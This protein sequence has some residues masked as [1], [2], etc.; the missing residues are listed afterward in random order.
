MG[1]PTET[2]LRYR[3]PW[4]WMFVL[5]AI[6]SVAAGFVVQNAR[7]RDAAARLQFE[8]AQ[9]LRLQRGKDRV[10]EYFAD[11]SQLANSGARMAQELP[12]D[13]KLIGSLL[14]AGFL[15][16]HDTAI[17]GY[18]VFYAPYAFDGRTRLVDLY[19][20]AGKKMYN[21]YDRVVGNMVEVVYAG[22]E[23]GP[24]DYTRYPWFKEALARPREVIY[25]GPYT[26]NQRSFI[27]TSRA[28]Y[29][30]GR[31]A[32]VVAVDALTDDFRKMLA[33]PLVSGDYAWMDAGSVYLL[34]TAP[35]PKNIPRVVQSAGI[36]YATLADLHLASDARPLAAI[37][38]RDAVEAAVVIILILGMAIVVAFG[39]LQRWRGEEGRR[40]L[41]L[42]RTKLEQE[43][44]TRRRVESELRRVAYLDDLTGLPNRLA[45]MDA[46]FALLGES[47]RSTHAVFLIDL[48]HFNITNETLG[49]PAGD[50][51]LR[52]VAAR[53]K[54]AIGG[55]ALVARLGG[56]EYVILSACT[57][58]TID[59]FS[60]LLLRAIAEPV[61]LYGRTM[62]PRA[63]IGVAV[64]DGS[65]RE[66]QEVLRDADI[67]MYAAKAA[68]RGRHT[69]FDTEMRDQIA[70]DSELEVQLRRALEHGEIVPYYQPVVD[71]RTYK[72]ISFE[73]LARWN[74]NGEIVPAYEFVAFAEARGFVHDIDAAIVRATLGQAKAIFA[75]FPDSSI[76]LNVSAPELSTP[77][78]ATHLLRLLEEHAVA[79]ERIRLEITETT[80][81]TRANETRE[82]LEQLAE[83]GVTVVL[84][85]FGTGYSSLA[86]LQRLSI[87]GVKIDRSFVENI[88]RDERA[89]EIVRSI[90]ALAQALGLTTIAEGVERAA[91]V[92]E[93]AL[94]GV[95]HGQGFFFSQAV[96]IGTLA[97]AEIPDEKPAAASREI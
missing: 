79:P 21:R 80:M 10:N 51:L 94:L 25:E 6:V 41:E 87:S 38:Q 46:L 83:S 8:S 4:Y 31:L 18:G 75:L 58:G 71:L 82:T 63:S 70:R 76:A 78:Y 27:T 12:A 91:Q 50:E 16:R 35:L 95:M 32:G 49:H 11:A 47:E 97:D 37:R 43:I 73:A 69:V 23:R 33:G 61:V 84:D 40:I 96:S 34:G 65:Y 17:Y 60:G 64:V 90:V 3:R 68:G 30:K 9:S 20:H 81:M 24:N 92:H 45:F 19:D 93:L 53:L 89:R 66:P 88:D 74:R 54:G 13:T 26:E 1:E 29:R 15:A 57:L 72:T 52:V 7:V 14:R 22:D 42:A 48:D 85:D 44:E 5:A 28:F 55:K 39:L 86:Y 36:A 56:D 59:E 67:A 77:D 62:H 2:S